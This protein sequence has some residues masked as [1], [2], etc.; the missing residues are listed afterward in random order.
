MLATI[1]CP[2]KK[3]S[4]KSPYLETKLKIANATH[5]VKILTL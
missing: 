3:S 5:H 1:F 2:I 4:N